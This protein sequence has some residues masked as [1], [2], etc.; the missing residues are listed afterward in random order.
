MVA[1]CGRVYMRINNLKVKN[2]E[3]LLFT[4]SALAIIALLFMIK[5]VPQQ[6]AWILERL[7]K[8]DRV[9]QPGL[10]I[11][12]PIIPVHYQGYKYLAI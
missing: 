2:M 3:A 9:L 10:N 5:I 8:Y 11:L 7:G 4:L 12:I 1:V 6:Q